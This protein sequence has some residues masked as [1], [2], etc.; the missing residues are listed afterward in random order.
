MQRLFMKA[1]LSLEKSIRCAEECI[2]VDANSSRRLHYY[3]NNVP[4][5]SLL[6]LGN[7]LLGVY[8]W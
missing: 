7:H 1:G 5:F 8:F 3:I 6:Q 2:L 4:G